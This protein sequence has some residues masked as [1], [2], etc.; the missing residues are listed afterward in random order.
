MG[1]ASVSNKIRG[2]IFVYF[3]T[4][5]Y[6]TLMTTRDQQY[7]AACTAWVPLHSEAEAL[8]PLVMASVNHFF[9]A[10]G[11]LWSQRGRQM[12]VRLSQ[13]PFGKKIVWLSKS[14]ATM[15][16]GTGWI[17]TWMQRDHTQ[18]Q[19]SEFMQS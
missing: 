15:R 13:L 16:I 19:L 14:S 4:T 6:N 11:C 17:E 3:S 1:H 10:D 2:V 5:R 8:D 12:C 18:S 7:T 9:V